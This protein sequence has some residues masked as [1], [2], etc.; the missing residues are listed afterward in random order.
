MT[1]EV[2]KTPVRIEHADGVT[3]YQKRTYLLR[4]E[5]LGVDS[6]NIGNHAFP[7]TRYKFTELQDWLDTECAFNVVGSIGITFSNVDDAMMC[8]LAWSGQLGSD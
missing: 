8:K 4:W 1:Y 3:V 6:R 7:V 2:M 5:E